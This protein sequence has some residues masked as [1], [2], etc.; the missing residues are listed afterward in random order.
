M[1]E[2][3]V[4][5]IDEILDTVVKGKEAWLGPARRVQTEEEFMLVLSEIALT[6]EEPFIQYLSNEIT[7]TVTTMQSS[8]RC[9]GST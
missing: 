3:I 4:D 5:A 1:D 6:Y 7:S 8:T 9:F 2:A